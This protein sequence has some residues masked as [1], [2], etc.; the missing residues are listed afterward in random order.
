M[1]KKL[2]SDNNLEDIADA[3]RHKGGEGVY[4]VGEMGDAIR[5]LDSSEEIVNGVIEQYKAST[6]TISAGTFVSFIE[7]RGSLIEGAQKDATSLTH[8]NVTPYLYA[9]RTVVRYTS[10]TLSY[11]YLFYLN[12]G[13]IYCTHCRFQSG[14]LTVSHPKQITSGQQPG[15]DYDV[16]RLGDSYYALLVF[17][18][19]ASGQ[20]RLYGRV[21][22][23]NGLPIGTSRPEVQLASVGVSPKVA[24]LDSTHAFV[25]YAHQP[26]SPGSTY[27]YGFVCTA[28]TGSDGQI[29]VGD[30]VSQILG[31]DYYGAVLTSLSDSSVFVAAEGKG[32]VCTI[33]G[34]TIT[35][36]T[37]ATVTDSTAT[38][39]N[40]QI[41]ALGSGAVFLH[42]RENNGYPYGVVC[43]VSGTTITKGTSVQLAASKY[44]Y[45][46]AC[47]TWNESRHT[48][49]FIVASHSSGSG[50]PYG[51]IC[52]VSG[53]TITVGAETALSVGS[54]T[55]YSRGLAAALV[56]INTTSA[57]VFVASQDASGL[58]AK[59]CTVSFSNST[60]T[61]GLTQH[62]V[63]TVTCSGYAASELYISSA[64]ALFETY[65][66]TASNTR[67]C[68]LRYVGGLSAIGQPTVLSTT[69]KGGDA[70]VNILSGTSS[71]YTFLVIHNNSGYPYGVVCTVSGTTITVGTEVQL[72]SVS[73]SYSGVSSTKIS[74]EKFYLA[75][76]KSQSLYNVVG[77]VSG[78]TITVETETSWAG[79]SSTITQVTRIG[80]NQVFVVYDGT[81]SH[82]LYGVVCT[83]SGTTIIVGTEQV[84][85]NY[86]STYPRPAIGVVSATENVIDV[87]V[88]FQRNS[89]LYGTICTLTISGGFKVGTPTQLAS[90]VRSGD[91]GNLG[92]VWSGFR[93]GSTSP[94]GVFIP[95]GYD[96]LYGLLC[97][98]SN[99]T[100]TVKETLELSDAGEYIGYSPLRALLLMQDTLSTASDYGC[101]L[102]S[103]TVGLHI[104]N[105]RSSNAETKALPMYTEFY[106]DGTTS[107]HFTPMGLTETEC[108]TSTAGD[109]WVLDTSNSS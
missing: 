36:G 87:F 89:V 24:S 100:I 88:S 97:T 104:T 77:T 105:I 3:I 26:T 19:Y 51:F 29:V 33:S 103:S 107:A 72:S 10:S 13:E 21:L 63:D 14:S 42:Y 38:M 84:I 80:E 94:D 7:S 35:K 53:T 41:G 81:S 71:A 4:T 95:Y 16:V 69:D 74:D 78:T 108:T 96:R 25:L 12:G 37:I 54:G 47:T 46:M 102:S 98:I 85:Y 64:P 39:Q 83:I 66:D 5:G 93:S 52:T 15:D 60:V 50:A 22:A 43:T 75:H 68:Q 31:S 27:L 44:Y 40:L 92:Y 17:T 30:T 9:P 106:A 34:T 8:A 65:V 28:S 79:V 61:D 86:N 18:G 55:Q 2:Y 101:V 70:F 90:Q 48:G 59:N 99:A 45:P 109:V 56:A 62:A 76:I 11:V 73:S 23:I 49:A 82:Y 67:Y 58:C 91:V 1:T 32:I 6:D 57:I 20:A